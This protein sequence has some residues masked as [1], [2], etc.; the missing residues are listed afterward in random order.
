MFGSLFIIPDLDFADN[1]E[2]GFT[3]HAVLALKKYKV[4]MVLIDNKGGGGT[5]RCMVIG[6]K[7]NLLR[8]LKADDG[9][10]LDGTPKDSGINIEPFN[11]ARGL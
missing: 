5:P 11:H 3:Q 8:W 4:S 2:Y 6:E 10:S 9:Y 1:E 7:N